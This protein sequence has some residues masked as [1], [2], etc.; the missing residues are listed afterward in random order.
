MSEVYQGRHQ[1]TGEPAAVKL[2]HPHVLATP[3]H[4]RRFVREAGIVAKLDEP[5][6]VRVL[7]VSQGGETLPYIAMEHLEGQ[8]LASYLKETPS[9]SVGE[10]VEM[11]R[12][13][14]RGLAA[15]HAAGI[16]HRDLKPH[17]LYRT[18]DENGAPLWKILD[19]GVCKLLAPQG[20]ET[21]VG[22][23]V[24]TPAYMAPEQACGREI[25]ASADYY[26]L[27]VVAYR[28][29]TGRPAFAAKPLDRLLCD[30]VF[31]QA[32]LPSET[33]GLSKET[34][35]V[36]AV[37]LAKRP[38]HRFTSGDDMANALAA[39]AAGALTPDV[40]RLS[41]EVCKAGPLKPLPAAAEPDPEVLSASAAETAV[42]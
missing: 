32:P 34:D 39:A 41:A 20:Q 36:F 17:N 15:A 30:I 31:R 22:R 23:L 21:Q 7:D 37:A 4:F 2:L 18:L 42:A 29:L 1:R 8:T 11:V 25:D 28:A 13:V 10:V 6:I 19:F 27:G 14:G 35:L 3:E 5:H 40:Q 38:E 24:G 12:Q 16:V 9:L 33:C 26:A